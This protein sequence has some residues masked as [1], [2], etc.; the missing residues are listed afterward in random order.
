M[1]KSSAAISKAF[2]KWRAKKKLTL[3]QVSDQVGIS[4]AYLS[5]FENGHIKEIGYD[6]GLTLTALVKGK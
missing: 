3:R 2:A 4:N 1:F 5:Q 6:K